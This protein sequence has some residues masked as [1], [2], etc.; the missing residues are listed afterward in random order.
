MR[1]ASLLWIVLGAG[2]VGQIRHGI[3]VHGRPDVCLPR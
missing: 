2:R 1:V 3:L